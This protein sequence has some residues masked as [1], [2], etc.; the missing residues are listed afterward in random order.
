MTFS[1][2]PRFVEAARDMMIASREAV[3]NYMTPLGLHHLMAR[4]HHYGPGPWVANAWR[5]D[6]T[7]VY[8]HRAD[9]QGLGFD[10]TASGSNAVAQYHPPLDERFGSLEDCPEE[11]L[12]WFHH[13]AWDHRMASGRTLW[14]ELCHRYQVGVDAVRAMQRT[15]DTLEAFVD[16]ARFKHVRTLLRSR[17]K[18]PAGGAMH[19]CS[20]S[21]PSRSGRSRRVMNRPKRP[22][23]NTSPSST[24]SCPASKNAVDVPRGVRPRRIAN[25]ARTQN[26]KYQHAIS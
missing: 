23:P 9:A 2:D 11:F 14:D 3:V 6:W 16:P 26:S 25:L 22:W 20:T 8:Y 4:G 1:N 5:A 7:S 17:K 12:L 18:K 10:R 13:V 21:R 24:I 19:A 15:W